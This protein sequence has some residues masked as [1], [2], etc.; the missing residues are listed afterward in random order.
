MT[1]TLLSRGLTEMMEPT[2]VAEPLTENDLALLRYMRQSFCCRENG[3]DCPALADCPEGFYICDAL[4]NMLEPGTSPELGYAAK[5]AVRFL[6]DQMDC[7][8]AANCPGYADCNGQKVEP[9]E[10]LLAKL[11]VER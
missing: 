4:V 2:S 5:R 6:Y 10:S 8:V 7:D 9:C 3:T 1:S 11:G